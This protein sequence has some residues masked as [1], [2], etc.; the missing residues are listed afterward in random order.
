VYRLCYFIPKSR[1][2]ASTHSDRLA[3]SILLHLPLHDTH[4]LSVYNLKRRIANLPSLSLK[5]FQEQVQP[6][7]S[8]AAA[9][10]EDGDTF[11]ETCTTCDKSFYSLKSLENH[12]KSRSHAKKI[13]DAI[14]EQETISLTKGKEPEGDAETIVSDDVDE[15]IESA[16]IST[17]CLFCNLESSTLDENVQHMHKTHG[18]F[19]PDP[20]NLID[21][22]SFLSYLYIIINSFQECIYCGSQKA[23]SEAV[24][25][26][27]RDKGHCVLSFEGDAGLELF[28]EQDEDDVSGVENQFE[29]LTMKGDENEMRLPSGKTLGHR[30]QARTT[31]QIRPARSTC[32]VQEGELT[33]GSRRA[34]AI[35]DGSTSVGTTADPRTGRQVVTRAHGGFGLIGVSQLQRRA[36]MATEK[37]ALKAE[38]RARN[39]YEGLVEKQSNRTYQVTYKVCLHP[40]SSFVCTILF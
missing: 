33:S 27:M 11:M 29:K 36:L 26:H 1:N 7:Q 18:L 39:R 4:N 10:D 16:F 3:V 14:P 19:I 35:T 6:L 38:R 28:W 23:N 24:R 2:S 25:S 5:I 12:Y 22:E 15:E 17:E 21:M 34:G 32:P 13:E 31:R 9:E 40:F 20:E 30:S 8:R 37:V